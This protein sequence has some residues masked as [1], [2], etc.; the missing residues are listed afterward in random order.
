MNII[1]L[2]FLFS[3]CNNRK[4]EYAKIPSIFF[5]LC[6]NKEKMREKLKKLSKINPI[7]KKTY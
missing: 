1:C 3:K 2:L 6:K 4:T 7:L 5:F